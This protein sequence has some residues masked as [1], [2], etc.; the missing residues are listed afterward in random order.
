MRAA[1]F[2][3]CCFIYTGVLLVVQYPIAYG[4]SV[5]LAGLPQVVVGGSI[6]AAGVLRLRRPAT[7]AQNPASYGLLAYGTAVLSVLLTV[8]FLGQVLVR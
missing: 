4:G 1:R 7:E 2:V 3:T 5:A 8:V 6:L